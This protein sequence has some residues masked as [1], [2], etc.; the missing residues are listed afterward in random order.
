VFAEFHVAFTAYIM[1]FV[2]VAVILRYVSFVAHWN[3]LIAIFKFTTLFCT[4]LNR[5]D[6]W[7]TVVFTFYC[8]TNFQTS[9]WQNFGGVG[10][11]G[12]RKLIVKYISK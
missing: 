8:W 9:D 5:Y 10:V 12:G 11:G 7:L 6:Y 2:C 1:Q 4:V 3:Y